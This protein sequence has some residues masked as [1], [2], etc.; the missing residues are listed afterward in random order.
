MSSIPLEQRR[1]DWMRPI[2]FILALG[3]GLLLIATLPGYAAPFYY[4]LDLFA[5]FRMHFL[6][7][8][9]LILVVAALLRARIALV[10]ALGAALSSGLGLIPLWQGVASTGDGIRVSVMAA[11]VYAYNADN[12]GMRRALVEADADIL[13]TVETTLAAFPE[14]S[15]LHELYPYR[16]AYRTYRTRL[17]TVLWSKFPIVKPGLQPADTEAPDTVRAIVEIT[18]GKTLAV[19][20]L[21]LAHVMISNQRDEIEELAHLIEDL[22][23]PYVVMGD[24]NATP[25]S[26]GMRRAEALTGARRVGGVIRTW[27]GVYPTPLGPVPEPFGIPIDHILVSDGIAAEKAERIHIPG[28]DHAGVRAVLHVP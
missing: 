6:G 12:A 25:W 15:E 14:D 24:F 27:H 20:G 28:S 3:A 1:R 16:V 26:W 10:L 21:H 18:P 11:N 8:A 19:L 13:L 2:R 9:V 7:F 23:A 4:D 5:H 17:G 22:P